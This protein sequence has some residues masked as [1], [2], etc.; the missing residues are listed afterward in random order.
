MFAIGADE[1]FN[2]TFN[3]A[4]LASHISIRGGPAP[5]RSQRKV[6]HSLLHTTGVR[7]TVQRGLG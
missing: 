5:V 3:L 6:Y 7:D 2:H 1:L 4:I